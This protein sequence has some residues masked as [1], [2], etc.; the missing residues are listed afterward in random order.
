[1]PCGSWRRL[2][3]SWTSSSLLALLALCSAAAAPRVKVIKLAV[4]NLTPLSR[5]SEN[6]V[7]PVGTLQAIAKDFTAGTA[8]VTTSQAETLDQDARTLT[9]LS[10]PSENIVIPVGTLQAIAKDF[11]A[12]TA[13]VT[14]SQA[15]TLDQ[16]AR[17]L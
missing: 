17:T 2:V 16:D 6:I 5:P 7:I 13:I 8:I 10:R 15:E 14:T 11:T 4:T 9:P 3:S 12:G 1:M